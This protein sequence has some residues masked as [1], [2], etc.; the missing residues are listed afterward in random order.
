MRK[1]LDWCRDFVW[2][3]WRWFVQVEDEVENA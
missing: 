3:A 2:L 1:I